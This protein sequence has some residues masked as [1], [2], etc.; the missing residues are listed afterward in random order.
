MNPQGEL[1]VLVVDDS[2]VKR[3]SISDMLNGGTK[4]N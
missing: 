3:R 4:T 1:R 2:A